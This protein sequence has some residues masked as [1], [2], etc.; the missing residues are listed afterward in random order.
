[1]RKSSMMASFLTSLISGI[2]GR[3]E[4]I[5]IPT[6]P[7]L[8]KRLAE[9]EIADRREQYLSQHRTPVEKKPVA[10]RNRINH[11]RLY[12]KLYVAK[13]KEKKA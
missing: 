9:K 1:M 13:M 11:V 6:D 3:G 7:E 5:S 8:S 10:P 2:K 12:H 4:E